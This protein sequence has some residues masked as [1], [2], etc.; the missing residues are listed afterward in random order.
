MPSLLVEAGL[1]F[2]VA[3]EEI[4]PEAVVLEVC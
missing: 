3:L 2:L 1:V 4:F